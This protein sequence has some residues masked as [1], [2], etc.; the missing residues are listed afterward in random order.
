MLVCPLFNEDGREFIER[1]CSVNPKYMKKEAVF[2]LSGCTLTLAHVM[3]LY[4]G[5][6]LLWFVVLFCPLFPREAS[7]RKENE[8]HQLLVGSP[9]NLKHALTCNI[10]FQTLVFI[11]NPLTLAV[12]IQQGE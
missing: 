7:K 6:C 1:F 10:V 2:L 11:M 5:C 4:T 3:L 12:R 8:M 9:R